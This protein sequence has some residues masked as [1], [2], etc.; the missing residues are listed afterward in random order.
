MMTFARS[1][2]LVQVHCQGEIGKVL[3]AGAPEIPG[4]TML[5]KMHHI[6][7]VDD[8]LRRFVTLEP[9]GFAQMSVNLL[10][11][12]TRPDA[13]A[14]FIVLQADRAHAD[15]RQQLHLRRHRL[16]GNRPRSR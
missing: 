5:D 15:V 3:M 12:P 14:G 9:R 13:D 11:A 6:N 2:E 4:A 16:A 7:K 8:S 1:I 10:V